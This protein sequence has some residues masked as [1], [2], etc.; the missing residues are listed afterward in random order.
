VEEA[1]LQP[2]AGAAVVV[3]GAAAAAAREEM[4]RMA[5]RVVLDQV[6]REEQACHSR[7]LV[8][9]GEIPKRMVRV[10]MAE[11]THPLVSQLEQ[12]VRQI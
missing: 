5:L 4:E 12:T 2:V 8:T 9:M 6:E 11:Q 7:F 10:G 1:Q 3:G